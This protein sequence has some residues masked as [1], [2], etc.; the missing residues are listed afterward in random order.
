MRCRSAGPARFLFR[1]QHVLAVVEERRATSL[2]RRAMRLAPRD[3]Y[4]DDVRMDSPD[5]NMREFRSTSMNEKSSSSGTWAVQ[6]IPRYIWCPATGVLL[7][8]TRLARGISREQATQAVEN[9]G[10]PAS[11]ASARGRAPCDRSVE[12][13]ELL[14]GS[15]PLWASLSSV[16]RGVRAD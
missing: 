7:G 3:A 10:L 5:G 12:S 4:H 16:G 13:G 1:A 6:K 9:K 11:A 8:S 15:A 2:Y 14:H